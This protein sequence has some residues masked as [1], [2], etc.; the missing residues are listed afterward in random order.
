MSIFTPN[1]NGELQPE[2]RSGHVSVYYQGLFMV[3]GGYG[4]QEGDHL[5]VKD[6]HL[7]CY[8]VEAAQWTRYT[9]KGKRETIIAIQLIFTFAKSTIET[10][11][12]GVKC[13]QS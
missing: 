5:P 3:Y 1:I 12:K 10:L 11:E 2:K 9:T 7:W 6:K 8:N 4:N 13:V